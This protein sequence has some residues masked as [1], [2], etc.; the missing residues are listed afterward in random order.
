MKLQKDTHPRLQ[1]DSSLSPT[2]DSLKLQQPT[3]SMYLSHVS[4]NGRVWHKGFLRWVRLQ[5]RSLPTLSDPQNTRSP[6]GISLKKGT[7]GTTRLTKPL[8]RGLEPEGRSPEAQGATFFARVAW[9]PVFR[10]P[11]QTASTDCHQ[12]HD[13]LDLIRVT[14]HLPD[15]STWFIYLSNIQTS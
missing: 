15:N 1:T 3:K 4:P 6:V 13:T 9:M 7:S 8:R 11:C 10:Y 14:K 2:A 5:D 12:N